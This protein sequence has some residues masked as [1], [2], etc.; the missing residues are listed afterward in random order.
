MNVNLEVDQEDHHHLLTVICPED[1]HAS[2][3]AQATQICLL[4]WMPLLVAATV[5]QDH[6]RV[7]LEEVP[8]DISER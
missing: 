5:G 6:H 1:H 8:E 3:T 2:V 4:I 7:S